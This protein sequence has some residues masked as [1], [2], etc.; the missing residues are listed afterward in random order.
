MGIWLAERHAV[1]GKPVLTQT[2]GTRTLSATMRNQ[3]PWILAVLLSLAAPTG[4]LVG[5]EPGSAA[6]P[7]GR[8]ML[9]MRNG[10]I[11]EGRI[12]SANGHYIIDLDDGQIRLKAAD[13][14]LVCD[15]LE[16]GYSRKRAAIQVGNVHHHLEL[17]Q[18]CLRHN[19]LDSAAAELA[20]AKTADPTHPMI[21][22][23]QH[24]LK[25]AMEP[26]T[27]TDSGPTKAAGPSNEELDRMVRGLP[28]G[29]VETFTQSVQPVLM[30]HCA[31]SGCHSPQ[32]E[33]MPLL[34]VSGSKPN[35][36]RITQ[37][38]LGS[39]LDFVDRDNIA[40]SR[41]LTAASGPHGTVQH[42]VFSE[43]EAA[44][45]NRLVEWV[46]QLAQQPASGVPATITPTMPAFPPDA[47]LGQTPP[48]VLSKD[49]LK[50][51]PLSASVH[52][53]AVRRGASPAALKAATD[54]A[55]ASFEQSADP[56]DPEVFNRRHA[57]AK[58]DETESP[59]K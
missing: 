2:G 52:N 13:V 26:Q 29:A 18:W 40:A 24:R 53:P 8:R 16:D 17:A 9:V 56:F 1:V 14:E 30:N 36:R 39:V 43:H 6:D 47:T 23:L 38:N 28:R 7:T 59:A 33:G 5:G 20:D 58:S 10:Q 37:R 57:S 21:A 55:Q 51:Q 45:Y 50:A 12:T 3:I 44:Q 42:A 32:A 41:L 25:M 46:C 11:F 15:T 54:A 27:A 22:A 35:S 19:L 34:R 48:Q 4:R 49:A 31:T